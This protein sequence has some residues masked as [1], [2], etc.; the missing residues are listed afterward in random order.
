MGELKVGKNILTEPTNYDTVKLRD[1]ITKKY[2]E[3]SGSAPQKLQDAHDAV[4]KIL[5]RRE[6]DQER[7]PVDTHKI[8][9]EPRNSAVL[10]LQKKMESP[11]AEKSGSLSKRVTHQS[12]ENK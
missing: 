3:L 12:S 2:G 11:P 8:I 5:K 1:K 9:A 6:S 10:R 4:A 7:V